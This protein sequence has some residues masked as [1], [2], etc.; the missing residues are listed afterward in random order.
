MTGNVDYIK[1]TEGTMTLLIGIAGFIGG[2]A[3]GI[4]LIGVFLRARS[5]SE[6]LQNKS[7]RWTYGLAVWVMAGFGAWAAVWVYQTYFAA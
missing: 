3:F 2:F 7:L 4:G 5:K 6:L 1:M